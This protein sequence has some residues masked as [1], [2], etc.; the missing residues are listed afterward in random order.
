MNTKLGFHLNQ[1]ELELAFRQFDHDG[2]RQISFEEFRNTLLQLK[3]DYLAYSKSTS[4]IKKLVA[5]I[6][7]SNQNIR[8]LF[9][10][11]LPLDAQTLDFF[12]FYAF[13]EQIDSTLTQQ[14]VLVIFPQSRL[15]AVCVARSG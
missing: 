1:F 2:D 15:A 13:I 3:Q 5:S 4:V 10:S 12:K 11:Q 9:Q 8:E 7:A 14:E 6:L